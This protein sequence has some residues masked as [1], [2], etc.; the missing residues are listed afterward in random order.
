MS[1]S[2]VN[3]NLSEFFVDLTGPSYYDNILARLPLNLPVEPSQTHE[4]TQKDIIAMKMR[5]ILSYFV[6]QIK[7]KVHMNIAM[8]SLVELARDCTSSTTRENV[9]SNIIK[10]KILLKTL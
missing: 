1:Q 9:M 8:K 4:I 5:V 7:T 10:L 2:T 6:K 3:T